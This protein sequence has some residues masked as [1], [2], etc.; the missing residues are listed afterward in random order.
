MPTDP[1]RGRALPEVAPLVQSRHRHP[2]EHRYLGAD[3][4]RTF[5]SGADVV[6]LPTK[7]ISAA[8]QA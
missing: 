3:I 2:E 4:L 6:P 7:R 8:G 5:A 1:E